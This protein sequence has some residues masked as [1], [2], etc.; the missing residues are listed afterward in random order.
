MH[1]ET[2]FFERFTLCGVTAPVMTS[3]QW[4]CDAV[5]LP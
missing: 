2:L 3:N 1:Q 5:V 4:H